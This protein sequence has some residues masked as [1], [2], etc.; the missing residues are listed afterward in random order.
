M[1]LVG[2]Y[3]PP[4]SVPAPAIAAAAEIL[5][6]YQRALTALSDHAQDVS[7]NQRG[8]I[9]AQ[10]AAHERDPVGMTRVLERYR[11]DPSSAATPFQSRANAMH[12]Q[13][14]RTLASY[15]QEH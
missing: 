7:S 1:T 14:A 11:E 6:Y 2:N 5:L 12:K 10:L 3:L 9:T 15:V 13:T 8:G 4:V